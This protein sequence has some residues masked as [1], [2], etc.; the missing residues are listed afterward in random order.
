[1]LRQ[2]LLKLSAGKEEPTVHS[3]FQIPARINE[4]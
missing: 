1:M 3:N 2:V 4:E